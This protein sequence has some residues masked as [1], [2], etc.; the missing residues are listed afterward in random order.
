MRLS[1]Q[2]RSCGGR[3]KPGGRRSNISV[4]RAG[5]PSANR[6]QA[7]AIA[8]IA[9]L[10]SAER[11]LGDLEQMVLEERGYDRQAELV[12]QRSSSIANASRIAF[13]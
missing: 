8:T 5:L 2:E 11:A 4:Y 3:S 6:R 12:T 7:V 10:G 13:R 9:R 1:A